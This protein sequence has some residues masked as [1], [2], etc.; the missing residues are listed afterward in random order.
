M[1]ISV[2]KRVPKREEDYLEAMLLISEKKK[3]IRIKDLAE[4]LNVRPPTVVEYL[5]KLA[6]KGLIRYE[7]HEYIHLTREGRELAKK[8]YDRHM[9]IKEMLVRFFQVPEDIAERDA[10]Y[11]EHGISSITMDRI[12]FFVKF[13]KECSDI[14]SRLAEYFKL[15]C[16]KKTCP[17]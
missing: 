8:I 2:P 6:R 17:Y 1:S 3:S 5:D 16:E 11:I 13:L 7:K 10:C 12:V 14:A 9:A 4:M 15:Y